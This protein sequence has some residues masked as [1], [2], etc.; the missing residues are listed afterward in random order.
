MIKRREI[1]THESIWNAI[2]K[3]A[4][5]N[6]FT[7]SGLACHGGLDAT[8]FNKSKRFDKYGKPRWPSTNSLAKI[9]N[10]TGKSPEE[11]I[12]LLGDTER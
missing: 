3:F 10:A 11:F 2:E 9:I 8:T 1:L 6:G 7:C 5:L 4:E 12:R